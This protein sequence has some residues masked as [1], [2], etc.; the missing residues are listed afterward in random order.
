M[1]DKSTK[2]DEK[3]TIIDEKRTIMDEKSTIFFL[4]TLGRLLL[5]K[6]T[7]LDADIG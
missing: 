7:I 2:M 6:S 3:S 5:E 4:R 1:D